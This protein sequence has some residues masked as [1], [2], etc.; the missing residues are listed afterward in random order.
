MKFHYNSS[1]SSLKMLEKG[2]LGKSETLPSPTGQANRLRD[3]KTSF[4]AIRCRSSSTI[5]ADTQSILSLELMTGVSEQLL[6]TFSLW[7]EL[8][9]GSSLMVLWTPLQIG[10][11]QESF[12]PKML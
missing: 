1:R 2:P 11:P 10:G 6:T 3:K 4:F 8:S 5:V 12:Q 9:N 7:L